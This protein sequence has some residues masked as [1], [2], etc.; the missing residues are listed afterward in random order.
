MNPSTEHLRKASASGIQALLDTNGNRT[1]YCVALPGTSVTIPIGQSLD[2][3]V[4]IV[5]NPKP[6]AVQ[7]AEM[8]PEGS[9]ALRYSGLP[10]STN[11]GMCDSCKCELDTLFVEAEDQGDV[12]IFFC[13]VCS[14]KY[15]AE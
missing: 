11:W 15:K 13:Q 8:N 14:K 4:A 9:G 10:R 2:S 1:G 3:T 12:D 7:V 6:R 5:A